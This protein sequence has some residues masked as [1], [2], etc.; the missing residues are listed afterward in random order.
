MLKDLSNSPLAAGVDARH[1]EA[2]A[3]YGV[4][5]EGA[6]ARLVKVPSGVEPSD[7]GLAISTSSTAISALTD[8]VLYLI[9]YSFECNEQ[10][11]SGVLGAAPPRKVGRRTRW[12]SPTIGG[13][14]PLAFAY[15]SVAHGEAGR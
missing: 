13:V 6:V 10:T 5:D 8:A 14:V 15:A 11:S 1:H 7:G 2:F 4:F 3:T 9:R 12:G